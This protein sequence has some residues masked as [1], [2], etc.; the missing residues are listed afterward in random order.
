MIARGTAAV[1]VALLMLGACGDGSSPSTTAAPP[2]ESGVVGSVLAGPVCPVVQDPPEPDCQ[3]RPVAGAV[4]LAVRPDG[5]RVAAAQT[6]AQGRFALSLPP[7][8]YRLVPQA[9]EGLLGTASPADVVV[10]AG[11][12]VELDFSYD[13]G[14]R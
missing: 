14:I 13:T 10:R 4:I 11:E 8:R 2:V 12:T 7:G 5:S 1:V 3:D 9:V 6:D